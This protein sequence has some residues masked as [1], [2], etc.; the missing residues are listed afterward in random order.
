MGVSRRTV[1]KWLKRYRQAGIEGL[2]DRSS[3]PHRSPKQTSPELEKRISELRSR[4]W[5][6]PRIAR[7]LGR[8]ISTVGRVLRRLGMQKLPPLV[9]PPPVIRYERARPGEMVHVDTKKL[10]RIAQVGHRIHQDQSKRVRGV[11]WEYLYVAVDDATRLAFT[12]ILPNEKGETA[13]LFLEQA[14]AW[15]QARQ[16]SI[17]RVMTDNGSCFRSRAFQSVRE[18]VGAKHV[19]TRPY[20][21]RT[22]GKAERFIQSAMKEWGYDV[23]YPSSEHR[24]TAL[25]E[26]TRMYNEA[27]PH[28]GICGRT[29][30]ERFQELQL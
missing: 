16:V 5:T 14:G 24:R 1:H 25:P 13:A 3:R 20:T 29:P 2:G 11:G 28:M 17:E 4:R 6:S 26:W 30:K 23:A 19:R 7:E 22:N 12:A 9:P 10:A 8:P 18:C 15:F 21:P 27:R